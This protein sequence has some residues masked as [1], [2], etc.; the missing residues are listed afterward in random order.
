MS[1]VTF[2]KEDSH[3]GS[4]ILVSPGFSLMNVPDEKK[5]APAVPDQ[6]EV[7]LDATAGMHLN[8]LL[9]HIRSGRKITAVSGYRTQEEQEQIWNDSIRDN[10]REFTR[11][12]VAIPGHS[13]HQTG[14]AI[15]LG[16]N[17][18]PVDFIRPAFPRNGI[19]ERFRQEAPRFG[20][21][22]RY[23]KGKEPVT[24]ISEEPWH[25]R[26]VGYPHSMIMAERNLT[27][28]EYISFLKCS[29][30]PSRPFYYRDSFTGS[31]KEMAI[32]Y[33]PVEEQT[34]TELPEEGL[35]HFSGT[36]EGGVIVTIERKQD[37]KTGISG[38]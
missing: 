16:E 35:C 14:L 29:T 34:R 12:Y 7:L 11:Q 33:L 37:E 23:R 15:D 28:E 19:C 22:E 4:L 5:M 13:E 3:T 9:N 32:F 1:A 26:Y 24:G 10:G 6:P 20:F 25:F 8:G 2:T 27:L 17:K 21:I 18:E 31:A 30:A 36:N 38:N